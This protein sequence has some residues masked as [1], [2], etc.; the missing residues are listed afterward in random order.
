[1][2][3][4]GSWLLVIYDDGMGKRVPTN[5]FRQQSRGGRGVMGAVEGVVCTALVQSESAD[6][7]IT[8]C[9]GKCIRI[10]ASDVRSVSRQSTGTR[11]MRL[12]DGDVPI[13]VV[14]V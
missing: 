2:A 4:T 14:V 3:K 11:L 1:M 6:V 7:I 10:S 9:A 5:Q 12:D 8:T 13:S